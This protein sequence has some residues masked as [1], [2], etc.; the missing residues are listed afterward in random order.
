MRDVFNIEPRPF[1]S[2]RQKVVICWSPKAACSHA[3]VW[4]FLQEDLLP[5]ANYYHGWPHKFRAEVYYKSHAVQKRWTDYFDGDPA[6][7]TLIKITRDPVKRMVASFRHVVRYPFFDEVVKQKV[8][9]DVISDGL[10]FV[11]FENTLSGLD[12]EPGSGVD[13]HVAKQE[14]PVWHQPFGKR[15]TL[16]LDETDLNTGL[17]ALAHVYGLK[18]INFDHFQK[19]DH[20]R[21]MH[22]AKDVAFDCARPETFRFKRKDWWMEF[23][24]S[25]LQGSGY[26]RR[27]A[28]RLYASDFPAVK[29]NVA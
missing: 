16:N 18:T 7:W 22:Y 4:F 11:D 13:I 3:T 12:L 9:V 19:F 21:N 10:S 28:E 8:G 1:I 26:V 20:L 17:N 14:H 15:H 29:G 6:E 2:T 27:A 24:K 23:P 5:A 25:V